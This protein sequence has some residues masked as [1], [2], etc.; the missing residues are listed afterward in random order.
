[1][2]LSAN[3][4]ISPWL[5]SRSS[6]LPESIS[7][8]RTTSRLADNTLHPQKS[9]LPKWPETISLEIKYP[10]ENPQLS[11]EILEI[12]EEPIQIAEGVEWLFESRA[13][14]LREIGFGV[15]HP[16][17][18]VRYQKGRGDWELYPY[19]VRTYLRQEP[20]YVERSSR[21]STDEQQ[22]D[23]LTSVKARRDVEKI[24]VW[25]QRFAN[26]RIEKVPLRLDLLSEE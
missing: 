22:V 23:R 8:L 11:R 14:R 15:D 21:V 26:T 6:K 25:R 17:A 9:S 13:D 24:E 12:P 4:S 7:L 1:M 2:T 5:V 3:I 18:F 16:C 19:H 20:K 10:L